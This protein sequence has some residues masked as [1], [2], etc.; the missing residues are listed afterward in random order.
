MDKK[1]YRKIRN[2]IIV[3]TGIIII[4]ITLINF[5]IYS[6][7]KDIA[8]SG[9][10][11]VAALYK[12]HGRYDKYPERLN[13]LVPEYLSEPIHED[14]IPDDGWT[15]N[16]Y[17]RDKETS[18]FTLFHYGIGYKTGVMYIDHRDIDGEEFGWEI[19]SEGSV[20]KLNLPD[21]RKKLTNK[22]MNKETIN[23]LVIIGVIILG[24]VSFIT[25]IRALFIGVVANKG[26]IFKKQEQSGN[27]YIT[28]LGYLLV[29]LL[30]ILVGLFSL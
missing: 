6:K 20:T 14:I 9:N 28:V 11:I 12:Y 15:Y 23:S 16:E 30:F 7:N 2:I 8:E 18:G 22:N 27:Y 19:N 4:L 3:F 25:G 10:H 24:I 1:F 17:N 21:P 13:D 26:V 5:I 29:G